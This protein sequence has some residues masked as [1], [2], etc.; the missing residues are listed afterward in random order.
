M[1]NLISIVGITFLYFFDIMYEF[2]RRERSY[3]YLRV[4]L[5]LCFMLI[6]ML[7]FPVW[8]DDEIIAQAVIFFLAGFETSSNLLGFAAHELAVNPD[9]QKKLQEEVDEVSAK[10]GGKVNY[11]DLHAM[12]Y[13]D[14][15][16]TGMHFF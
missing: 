2:P 16:I 11:T 13:M 3:L 10:C 6:I 9:I 12:K 14:M 1:K 5:S 15:V 4:I 7:P 8:T